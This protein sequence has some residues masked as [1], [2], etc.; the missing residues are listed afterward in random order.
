MH[1][2]LSTVA[3]AVSSLLLSSG[4]ASVV[5]HRSWPVQVASNPPGASFEIRNTQGA[6]VRSGVTPAAT[7]LDSG[8]GYFTKANYTITLTHQGYTAANATIEPRL[9][10]WYWGNLVFGGL[11]GLLFVDP[12][13]GAMYRI[14]DL[15]RYDLPPLRTPADR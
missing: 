9:N 11:V 14:D 1:P 15:P 12:M 4:C 5:S 3:L 8:S 7:E 10:G 2:S 6:V 13:T